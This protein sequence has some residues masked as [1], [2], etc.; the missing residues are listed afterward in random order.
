MFQISRVD[1]S[2]FRTN[3]MEAT[4]Q[5]YCGIL[6]MPLL[7]AMRGGEGGSRSRRY[8]I[9]AG[10]HNRLVFFDGHTLPPEGS[11]QLLDHFSIHV[12]TQE[13]FDDAYQRVKAHGVEVTDIIERAYGKT[14]YF[15][16][17]NG[18]LLQIGLDTKPDP[19]RMDDPDPV[20]SARKY[21]G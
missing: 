16:D 19:R 15:H 1:H 6:G 21:V 14:F 9:G 20:P 2:A 17:P 5:F 4:V 10:P 12:E 11:A 3:D 8:V 13:E 18:I 7:Q